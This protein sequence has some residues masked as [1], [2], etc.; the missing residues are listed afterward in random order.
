MS[1]YSH[2]SLRVCLLLGVCLLLLLIKSYVL[3]DV[4]L[5]LGVRGE[6]RSW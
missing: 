1:L 5:K 6:L 4:R 3:L 2:T